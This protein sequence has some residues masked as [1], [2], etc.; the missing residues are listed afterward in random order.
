[1]IKPLS[2]DNQSNSVGNIFSKQTA[3]TV[4]GLLYSLAI[5]MASTLRLE[6]LG[7]RLLRELISA[8][9]VVHGAF[10]LI[11]EEGKI[12]EVIHEGYTLTPEF[13]ENEIKIL[14]NQEK[15]LV[16]SELPEGELKDI[17]QG[18]DVSLVVY[19]RT[20]EENIGLLLLSKK[21][22]GAPYKP[23]DMQTLKILAPVAAV[24]FQN[25]RSFEEIRQFNTTL[26][27]K[28]AQATNE[29]KS[30]NEGV[31]K[32][33]LEL[34]KVSE[35]L[36][37]AN[38]KL[39][40]FDK[41]KDEFLS[42]AS[43]E[44]RTPMTAIK[45]FIS[46][47]EEGDY[48]EVGD[49]L[50]TPLRDI[51]IST[52]RLIKLVNDMLNISRIEAGRLKFAISEFFIN[53]LLSDIVSSLQPLAKEKRI[54]LEI[55]EFE[56]IRVQGDEDKVRQI[57]DNLIGNALKFTDKGGVT[58]SKRSK[59][60]EIEILVADTG[61]GIAQE[62]QGKLFKKFELIQPQD[63]G[64]PTGSG[65]GL[66]ISREIARKMGGDVWLE[67]SIKDKGSTFVF[68]LPLAKM[69]IAKKVKAEIEKEALAHPDQKTLV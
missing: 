50:R 67:R 29:L 31:Y 37:R 62:D 38:R 33:N 46:M 23:Y 10:V 59:D 40:A 48:G 60:E 25:A 13:D 63:V 45:G 12:Y 66:Y 61:I 11:G 49:K 32:R 7:H 30:V 44:L 1:M 64:R 24:A 34:A 42:V 21:L 16:F 22:L 14:S 19:L 65:L 51:E 53:D 17:M 57:L 47:I 36:S 58:L 56:K 9:R 28:V 43:H 3:Y 27:Q 39:K 15:M 55:S 20:E 5:I 52:D 68:S 8:M 6:D 2:M 41:L 69:D 18:L 54:S 4:Q 26:E 35:D